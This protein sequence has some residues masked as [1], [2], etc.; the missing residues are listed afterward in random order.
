MLRFF[1]LSIRGIGGTGRVVVIKNCQFLSMAGPID[2][3][4]RVDLNR[5]HNDMGSHGII[6]IVALPYF[7]AITAGV[8]HICKPPYRDNAGPLWRRE[9]LP[10][11]HGITEGG[12]G[13][14]VCGKGKPRDFQQ[15]LT[16]VQFSDIPLLIP[17]V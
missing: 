10:I 17:D 3:T 11:T 6:A 1:V 9:K 7:H 13:N 15:H 8:L 14:I 4:G 12:I 16:S 2:K 5:L